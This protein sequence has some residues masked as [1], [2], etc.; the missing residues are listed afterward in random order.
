ME[1]TLENMKTTLIDVVHAVKRTLSTISKMGLLVK[2]VKI[3]VL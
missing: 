1:K 3:I 2:N